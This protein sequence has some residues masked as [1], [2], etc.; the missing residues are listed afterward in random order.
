[1]SNFDLFEEGLIPLADAAK[2]LPHRKGKAVHFSTLYRWGQRGLDGVR[3][4]VVQAGGTKCTSRAALS[5]FFQ[6]L[7]GKE[8]TATARTPARRAKAVDRAERE[9]SQVG[10]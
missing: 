3:L 4:E 1:M 7:S 8:P 9:L 5:R 2:F 10:I 6:R